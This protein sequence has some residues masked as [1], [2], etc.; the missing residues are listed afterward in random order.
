MNGSKSE[1]IAAL[2]NRIKET[3]QEPE[4]FNYM[5][6]RIKTMEFLKMAECTFKPV[7]NE[8]SRDMVVNIDRSRPSHNCLETPEKHERKLSA[9]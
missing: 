4:P 7:I 5:R 8:T 1:R 3:L 9:D 2:R 6:D